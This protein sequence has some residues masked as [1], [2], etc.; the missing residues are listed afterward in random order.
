MTWAVCMANKLPKCAGL[1][2]ARGGCRGLYGHFTGT[3]RAND[4]IIRRSRRHIHEIAVF[5]QHPLSPCVD[6]FRRHCGLP[7]DSRRSSTAA[8]V[9]EDAEFFEKNIRPVLAEKCYSC[10]SAQAK[11]LKGKLLLDTRQGI[12]KGGEN[13]AAITGRDPDQSRLIQAIRWTTPIFR[14]RRKRS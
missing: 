7:T 9:K 5:H 12:A 10:H 3:R 4:A 14:C 6:E 13:G 11:K 1:A 2:N 8:I